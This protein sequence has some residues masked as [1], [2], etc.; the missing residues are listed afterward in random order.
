MTTYRVGGINPIRR[1]KTLTEA[2]EKAKHD[3]VIEIHKKITEHVVIN[4]PLH[5][6][7]NGNVWS[8]EAG[9]MGLVIDRTAV[10]EGLTFDIGSRS[11]AIVIN[12]ETILKDI[13]VTIRR[14]VTEFYPA[15]WVKSGVKHK[16]YNSTLTTVMTRE[17]TA[18]ELHDTVL[19]NYYGDIE[20]AERSE[21]SEFRGYALLKNCIVSSAIFYDVDAIDTAFGLHSQ[22]HDASL[23]NITLEHR[24]EL[25]KYAIKPSHVKKEPEHGPLSSRTNNQYHI[26]GTGH[27]NITRYDVPNQTDITGFQLMKAQVVVNDISQNDNNIT[28]R[29]YDTSISFNKSMDNNYWSCDHSPVQMVKSTVNTNVDYKTAMES[30]DEL[31]GLQSVKQQLK[32]LLNTIELGGG[33][34]FS[35]H[36]IFAGDAGTGKTT[37]AKLTAQALYEIGAI[38]ENKCT[39]ASTDTLIKGYVGQTASNVAEI[40]EG[41]LGGVLFIDEAYELATKQDS[42]SFN[43]EA[44]SV[45][46]RYMEDHRD[47]FVVIAAGYSKEMREFLASNIGLSRRFQWIEFDDYNANDMFN[48]F[49]LMRKQN[50]DDYSGDVDPRVIEKLFDKLITLNK[51]KP[52]T[53]GRITNGGNGGLVRNVYQK[54]T[55]A[56]N[57]RYTQFGGELLITKDDIA[58]GFEREIKQTLQKQ[59]QA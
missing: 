14:P 23:N 35:N 49:E 30:L 50:D 33:K 37:V 46:I 10:V 6:K 27:I 51:S 31:V 44:I 54:I 59:G 40:C 56:K 39:F 15:V 21:S 11:N 52:D 1:C 41:A 12:D 48:I 57:D 9:K 38:P 29:A 17:G 18:V 28:H 43:S 42:N 45:L 58:K 16:F 3:D 53:N 36:M 26:Y 8:V 5:I 13:T 7:G 20:T 32:S 34:D 24:S 22:V 4:K 47:K 2:V 25:M 55:Q 19:Y